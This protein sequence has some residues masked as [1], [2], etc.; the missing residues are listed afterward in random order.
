M[1]IINKIF[2]GAKLKKIYFIIF[3]YFDDDEETA[4]SSTLEYIPAPGSPTYE[5]HMRKNQKQDS[6]SE[7]DPL[8]AFMAGIDA[9]IQKSKVADPEERKDDKHKGIRADID[10]EDDEESY[11]R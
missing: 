5:E 8:D 6:D 2:A 1:N 3:R 11:Y 9:E 7:E 4:T 10:G